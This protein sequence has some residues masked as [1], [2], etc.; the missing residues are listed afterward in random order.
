MEH[1]IT[2]PQR[3]RHSISKG[4]KKHARCMWKLTLKG[5]QLKYLLHFQL[6]NLGVSPHDV[7]WSKVTMTCD[8]HICVRCN[9]IE[10]H[11]EDKVCRGLEN[12]VHS[13]I[14]KLPVIFFGHC[15]CTAHSTCQAGIFYWQN[16]TTIVIS[17]QHASNCIKKTQYCHF[18]LY[19]TSRLLQ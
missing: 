14:W 5:L 9:E 17:L 7:T 13:R 2:W 3:I 6:S 18:F 15:P 12:S 1:Y 8:K 11:T 10:G 16:D 4:L 19:K